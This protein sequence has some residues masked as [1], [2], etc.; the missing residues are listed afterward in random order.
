MSG[1]FQIVTRQMNWVKIP[2][3]K[4]HQIQGLRNIILYLIFHIL[5]YKWIATTSPQNFKTNV[6]KNGASQNRTQ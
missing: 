6:L 2:F 4:F 5:S 1:E 3:L